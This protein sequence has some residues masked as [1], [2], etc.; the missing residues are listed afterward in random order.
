VGS[1]IDEK[2]YLACCVMCIHCYRCM[3]GPVKLNVRE[4]NFVWQQSLEEYMVLVKIIFGCVW[5]VS[6]VI[7]YGV[8]ILKKKNLNKSVINTLN[9]S[10]WKNLLC[11]AFWVSLQCGSMCGRMKKFLSNTL[12]GVKLSTAYYLLKKDLFHRGLEF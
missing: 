11:Y 6:Y 9:L 1:G 12:Y 4:W 10:G 3:L 8:V 2:Q 5:K 7:D